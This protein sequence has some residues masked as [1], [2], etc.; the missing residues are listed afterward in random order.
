MVCRATRRGDELREK[1]RGENGTRVNHDQPGAHRATFGVDLLARGLCVGVSDSVSCACPSD[2]AQRAGA[3]KQPCT[4]DRA[5]DGGVAT[6]V[7]PMMRA[8]CRV[9][10][11][12]ASASM[13]TRGLSNKGQAPFA[14]SPE[15]QFRLA[16]QVWS[17]VISN[18]SFLTRRVDVPHGRAKQGGVRYS[19]VKL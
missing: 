1:L 4:R 17:P 7:H 12:R 14:A 8:I 11:R 5:T 19:Q 6:H 9:V 18:S 2:R 13:Y 10:D 16:K 15:K 3:S